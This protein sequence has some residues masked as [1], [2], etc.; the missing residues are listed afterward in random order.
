[1]TGVQT[2]ALPICLLR[3][4]VT[5]A[6]AMAERL[7]TEAPPFSAEGDEDE[8]GYAGFFGRFLGKL[9]ENVASVNERVEEECRDLLSFATRRI[10]INL[11]ILD[12]TFDYATVTAPVDPRPGGPRPPPP[13]GAPPGKPPEGLQGRRRRRRRGRQARAQ[14]TVP[15][16]Y[17]IASRAARAPLMNIAEELS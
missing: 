16:T 17:C 7:G 8:A 15:R 9:E 3:D 11:A 6:R 4:L 2:C 14:G 12:P 10:F 13:R 5:R 1:M